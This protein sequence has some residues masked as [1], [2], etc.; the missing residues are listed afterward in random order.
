MSIAPTLRT[1]TALLL[2]LAACHQEPAATAP[3]TVAGDTEL[4]AVH[5]GRLCD[6]YATDPATGA[7][8]LWQRDQLIGAEVTDDPDQ[9]WSFLPS[10]VETLQPRLWIASADGTAGFTAALQ[11]VQRRVQLLTPL[12]Y[13][14]GNTVFDVVPRNAALRLTFS[15]ELGIDDR[16]F[17]ATD[18]GASMPRVRNQD[19]VQLLQLRGTASDGKAITSPLPVRV[20]VQGN[21]LVVDPV[22]LG[23]EAL[24]WQ[25]PPNVAGLPAS[26]QQQGANL[27]L[28]V[29][30]TGPLALRGVRGRQP[31]L[32]GTDN[33]GQPAIVRDFRSGNRGDNT[34]AQAGGFLRDGRPLHL[35]GDVPMRIEHVAAVDAASCDV[36][37]F[38]DGVAHDVDAGDGLVVAAT[39]AGAGPIATEV[40]RDPLADRDQPGVDHVVVRVRAVPGLLELSPVGTPPNDPAQ[41]AE[42]LRAHAAAAALRAPFTASRGDDI[43]WFLP[44]DPPPPRGQG[45]PVPPGTDVST[46]AS[47]LLRFDKPVDLDS[48]RPLDTMFFA[49]RDLLSLD[50]IEQFRSERGLSPALFS[51]ARFRTPYLIGS[52]VQDVDGTQTLLRLQPL[53]GFYLD[54]AMR[55]AAAQGTPYRYYLHLLA[56]SLGLRDLAGQPLDL[57]AGGA[58]LPFVVLPFTVDARRTN[59]IPT[60]PDNR[61]VY[62]VRRFAA[63][64]EDEQP[65]Y[66]R[67][68]EW[69]GATARSEVELPDLFG[70]HY[71]QDG[72]LMARPTARV[73]AIADD[74]NQL[75]PPPETLPTR[76]CP[77]GSSASR[78]VVPPFTGGIQNPLNP[79]GARLQVAWREVDLSLSRVDANDMDLDIEAI[80][81]APFRG[82][83]LLFDE[84]DRTSL[85]LGHSERRPE[86]CADPFLLPA[87]PESG[88]GTD[89]L[90]NYLHNP[91]LDGS[92]LDSAPARHPGYVDQPLTVD[93]QAAVQGRGGNLY[94]PLP[95]LQQPYF[96]WRDQ[97]VTEQGGEIGQ[98]AAPSDTRLSRAYQPYIPSPWR[99]GRGDATPLGLAPGIHGQMNNFH[100]MKLANRSAADAA[101]G[102][103]LPSIALPL[104]ADFETFCDS[105]DLPLG[106]GYIAQGTNGWQ[107]ALAMTTASTPNFRSFSGGKPGYCVGPGTPDW[108]TAR[109]GFDLNGNRT[110]NTGDNSFYWVMLDLLK[111]R[112]VSTS[113]FVDLRNPHRMPANA[114]DP[115]L[116]PFAAATP[117]FAVMLDPQSSQQPA[118]TSVTVQFRAAGEVDPA[119]W[120]FAEEVPP[121][122]FARPDADN[123]PLDPFKACDAHLRKYDDRSGRNGWTHFYQRVVTDYVEDPNQLFAGSFTDRYAQPGLPFTPPDIRYVNW[124]FLMRN[125]ADR[126]PPVSP[127]VDTFVLAWRLR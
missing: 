75:Q 116:G 21:L 78:T 77:Q 94:M 100:N 36:T 103:L 88:L 80:W 86:P 13:D 14:Q 50:A 74:N 47:V 11:E 29:A 43:R 59:G 15:R 72:R 4:L 27:R 90:R 61:V 40:L 30:L 79:Y 57:G 51:E 23:P 34:Q 101:T 17:T 120:A 114:T 89:F 104:L 54:D 124:R 68:G 87:F 46:F 9:R 115:R 35:L 93:P 52:R 127:S 70:A 73:Q 82:Q 91:N 37:L 25:S 31:A 117:E 125:A 19:A 85:Y 96:T 1:C 48:A 105:P 58:S 8:S 24:V 12:R 122:Q 95:P 41:R 97:T 111:Q 22:L 44:F 3:A 10:D 18:P 99:N 53:L 45:G 7:P 66:D 76:W 6:V 65:S 64:D 81:W 42:W 49:T 102:G 123:V 119:P 62:C 56:G 84:F 28:A 5:W 32:L 2:L 60:Q 113:G 39:T 33:R 38:K 26:P 121:Q 83:A 63:V 69:S 126:T 118:G 20:A 106:N 55:D 108:G 110:P 92:Y 98:N 71:L 107:V 112:T 67:P 109:G 16:F